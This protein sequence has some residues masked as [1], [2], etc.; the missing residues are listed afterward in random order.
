MFAEYFS[1]IFFNQQISNLTI[2]FPCKKISEFSKSN[3]K[4]VLNRNKQELRI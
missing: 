3:P 2:N 4:T 1:D